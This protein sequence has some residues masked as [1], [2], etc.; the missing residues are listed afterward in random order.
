MRI[1]WGD[2]HQAGIYTFEYL[3]QLCPCETCRAQRP[4][5]DTPYVHGIYIP[6]G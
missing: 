1:H 2:G 3:R 6:K 4:T 5:D